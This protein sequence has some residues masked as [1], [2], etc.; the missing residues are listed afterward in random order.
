MTAESFKYEVFSQALG[1]KN[2]MM[3]KKFPTGKQGRSNKGKK[4]VL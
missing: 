2:I 1:E 4:E 3:A